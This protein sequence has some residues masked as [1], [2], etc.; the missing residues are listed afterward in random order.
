MKKKKT[1]RPLD[2]V[3]R[4]NRAG[5]IALIVSLIAVYCVTSLRMTGTLT[6]TMELIDG[7]ASIRFLDVGQGD[8]TLVVHRGHAVLIDAGGEFL[9]VFHRRD[10][11]PVRSPP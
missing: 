8:C 7:R 11:R 1:A 9:R 4:V 5:M 3:D 10:R 6:P 2:P